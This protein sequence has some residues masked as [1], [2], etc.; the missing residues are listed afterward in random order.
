MVVQ[1]QNEET[2]IKRYELHFTRPVGEVG[3]VEYCLITTDVKGVELW[4]D[5]DT[6]IDEAG[7][8]RLFD[9][10]RPDIITVSNEMRTLSADSSAFW[11]CRLM[12]SFNRGEI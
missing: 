9:T 6:P 2:V 3:L 12:T 5:D 10:F 7:I 8:L 11:A 1:Q 4:G